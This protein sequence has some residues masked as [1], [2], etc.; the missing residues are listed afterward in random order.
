MLEV[1]RRV[2]AVRR[3]AAG[4]YS[5]LSCTQSS[6]KQVSTLLHHYVC[7]LA[8][9]VLPRLLPAGPFSEALRKTSGQ[10][11]RI[12]LS[13]RPLRMC[14]FHRGLCRA[15]L[16]S[17][18]QGRLGKCG[19][20]SSMRERRLQRSQLCMLVLLFWGGLHF[21]REATYE[22]S[23]MALCTSASPV[24]SCAGRYVQA[25]FADGHNNRAEEWLQWLQ[26][27]N[28]L[29]WVGCGHRGSSLFPARCFE[30]VPGLVQS[31]CW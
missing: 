29:I 6:D 27:S 16:G 1:V 13:P 22:K 4:R 10:L 18:L 19:V 12:N 30:E 24:Q 5:R 28:N 20:R 8:S 21:S 7:L 11:V 15:T 25:S 17:K 14:V 9:T 31:L 2:T 3:P 23:L 26:P